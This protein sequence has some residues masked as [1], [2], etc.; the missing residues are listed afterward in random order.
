MTLTPTEIVAIYTILEIEPN[1]LMSQILALGDDLTAERELQIRAEIA[2]WNAAD[3]GD[4]VKIHPM[5]SNFGVETFPEE[6]KAR[7]MRRIGLSLDLYQSANTCGIF[8][9]E[10]GC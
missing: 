9:F 5:N 1:L 7:A 10:V 8:T 4:F 2:K 3:A 6:I